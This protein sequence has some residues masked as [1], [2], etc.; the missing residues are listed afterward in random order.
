MILYKGEILEDSRQE[1]IIASL[2]NELYK[3][4]EAG[5]ELPLDKVINACDS[6]ARA[7]LDGVYDEILLP[8]L[9]KFSIS[10]QR[11]IGMARLFLEKSLKYKCSV[12]L[13]DDERLIDGGIIRKR[14]PLGVLLH[15]AA[16][17]VDALPAYSVIEGLLSGNI[18]ILKLP[19]GDSGLSVLLLGELIK[20]EPALTDYIYV[21]DVPS[22]ETQ[23]LK[24][25]A[26]L[27]D[28][29]VV[30][31]GDMAVKAA[32]QLT[33][34]NTKIIEWGHKL[35]FA[36]A[37]IS[38]D[39]EQ[40]ME[41][42]ENVCATNQLLCSSCQGI[43]VDTQSYQ[44]QI[45]FAGRFFEA[46]KRINSTVGQVDFGMRAKNA[47]SIYNE[48]LEQH[49]T[50]NVIMSSGGVSVICTDDS[51][52]K[53]SYLYRNVWVKR[54]THDKIVQ[55]LKP[56]KNYLQTAAVLCPNHEKRAEI[57]KKLANA[58]VV[59]ITSGGNMSRTVCGEAHD[60]RY[61]LREYSRIVESEFV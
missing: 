58:G 5:K 6:L 48:R 37:D 3:P 15:I 16:G 56:Y 35:S 42:A 43:F 23:T 59:R 27:C 60:G 45:S 57:C 61:P 8:Y 24:S 20:I 36:Y 32:R 18:N 46:L 31:G 49:S 4:L 41:L 38:A 25:L 19:A 40:L 28:A 9:K 53:L 7:V 10:R 39:E 33:G 50:K 22:T 14:L 51:E 2:R 29:V 26:D 44:E 21:F 11:F 13:C 30:W 52:L 34:V 54:L 1:E 12:E 17:N 55:T 47:I